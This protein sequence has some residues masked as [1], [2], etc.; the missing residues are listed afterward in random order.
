MPKSRHVAKPGV[1][2]FQA[3]SVVL[4]HPP[5]QS[6]IYDT[7]RKMLDNGTARDVKKARGLF[8]IGTHVEKSPG[9]FDMA[10]L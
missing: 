5:R 8:N 10:A 9:L 2:H 4:R 1:P 7:L 6:V 3:T